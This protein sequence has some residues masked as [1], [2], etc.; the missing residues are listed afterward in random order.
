MKDLLEFADIAVKALEDFS[1]SGKNAASLGYYLESAMKAHII[2][3][4][5]KL[6]F[7]ESLAACIVGLLNYLLL[8][9]WH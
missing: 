7:W 9:Y 6:H 5:R 3:R 2:F 1:V 4:E 8:S